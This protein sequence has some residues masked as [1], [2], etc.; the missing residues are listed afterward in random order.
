MGTVIAGT[1]ISVM[2]VIVML[3]IL[4]MSVRK[5]IFTHSIKRK[6]YNTCKYV[7]DKLKM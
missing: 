7:A 5:V 1:G 2:A 4:V 6:I 3:G